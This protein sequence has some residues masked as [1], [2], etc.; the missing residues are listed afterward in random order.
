V[1]QTAPVLALDGAMPLIEWHGGQR[2]YKAP[3]EQATRIREVA[4]AAGGHATLFRLPAGADV[5]TGIPRFDVLS[6][7]VERI[8]RALMH[9]FDPH[10][11]FHRGRLIADA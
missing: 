3:P 5:H 1:P 9:E 7:P 4:R 10:S 6:T 8:H 2:W 11:L